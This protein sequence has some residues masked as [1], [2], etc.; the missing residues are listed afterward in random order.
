MKTITVTVLLTDRF[1]SPKKWIVE[2]PAMPPGKA[3]AYLYELSNMPTD[4]LGDDQLETLARHPRT[5]LRSVSVGD[6]LI[7]PDTD[8]PDMRHI[9]T[10]ERMGFKFH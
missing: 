9:A 10:V 3:A 4:I 2:I 5:G 7:I 6:V 8:R 1:E